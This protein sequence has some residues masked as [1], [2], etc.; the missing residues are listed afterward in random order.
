MS[1]DITMP[2]VNPVDW[3]DK[4]IKYT[5]EV[6]LPTVITFAF[7]FGGWK[8][9][10]RFMT[11]HEKLVDTLTESTQQQRASLEQIK[12]TT[13]IQA[14]TMQ[15]ISTNQLQFIENQKDIITGMK[16][17]DNALRDLV[18]ELKNK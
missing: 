3:V 12:E 11:S 14:S 7:L 17:S 18:R 2:S 8:V 6:G 15:I 16:E 10:E 4:L 9:S 5:K 13:S 1:K